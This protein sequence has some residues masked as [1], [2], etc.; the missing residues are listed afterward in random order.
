MRSKYA[1]TFIGLYCRYFQNNKNVIYC[2]DP[3]RE[4]FVIPLFMYSL[5]PSWMQWSVRS[6]WY[7]SSY[8]K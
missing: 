3:N 6:A 1:L 4:M 2:A 8:I 5:L 7:N